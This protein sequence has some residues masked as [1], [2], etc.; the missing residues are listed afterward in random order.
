MKKNIL[1]LILVLVTLNACNLA[2]KTA[3]PED[4]VGQWLL[5]FEDLPSFG[6]V[7][8]KLNISYKDSILTGYLFDMKN[9]KT[10]FTE[11]KMLDYQLMAKYN[12]GGK[13]VRFKINL[14]DETTNQ[15][16]GKFMWLFDVK[17]HRLVKSRRSKK[18]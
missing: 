12:W 2:T 15:I 14:V 8:A 17:G 6:D 4:F 18:K 16:E 1:S 5:T 3:K 7:K 9:G 13:D 11:L 10:P